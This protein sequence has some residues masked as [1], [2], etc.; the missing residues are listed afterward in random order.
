MGIELVSILEVP[1]EAF[2]DYMMGTLQRVKV[3]L[4]SLSNNGT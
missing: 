1:H 2:K 4:K 3:P